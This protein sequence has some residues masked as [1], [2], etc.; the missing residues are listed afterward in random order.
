MLYIRIKS[1][2]STS[3]D[4][5]MYYVGIPSLLR[6]KPISPLQLTTFVLMFGYSYLTAQSPSAKYLPSY[7][8]VSWV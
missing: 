5:I 4:W 8:D 3:V 1:I 7:A 2:L 6:L